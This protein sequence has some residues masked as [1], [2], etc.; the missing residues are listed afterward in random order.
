MKNNIVLI[1]F[2]GVG[3]GSLSR[4]LVK[5]LD[6]MAIDTDDLIESMENRF[7]KKIFKKEGEPYFRELENKVCRWISESVD[8]T[9]ISTGGGFPIHVDNPQAMGKVFYLKSS[10]DGIMDRIYSS[11]NPKKKLQK[12]PLFADP[13]KAKKLFD[14]RQ[15]RYAEVADVVIEMEGK[16]LE[17][18]V[19]EVLANR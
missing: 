17:K 11:K 5:E 2:M 10:F 13:K 6:M 8:N 19:K 14:S 4:A 16:S 3:K 18:I 1:G 9:I 12:R 15:K 7:V